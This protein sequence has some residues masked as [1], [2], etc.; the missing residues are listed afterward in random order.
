VLIPIGAGGMTTETDGTQAAS[1]QDEPLQRDNICGGLGAQ[2][3][4]RVRKNPMISSSARRVG[5][6]S[7]SMRCAVTTLCGFFAQPSK[8]WSIAR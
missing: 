3:P 1:F 8:Q 2:P 5:S 4:S 7:R 6:P